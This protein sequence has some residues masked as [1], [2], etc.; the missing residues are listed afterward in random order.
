MRTTQE[1]IMITSDKVLPRN[2]WEWLLLPFIIGIMTLSLIEG[3]SKIMVLY[4]ILL[5]WLFLIYFLYQK[6][7]LQPEVMLFFAWLIWSIIGL[8]TAIDLNLYVQNLK[9]IIQMA[10]LIFTVAGITALNRNLITL[11]FAIALGGAI[12]LLSGYFTGDFQIAS[13]ISSRTR[14][15]GLAENANEFAYLLLFLIFAIFFFWESRSSLGWRVLLL[16]LVTFAV[17]GIIYSGSRKIFLAFLAF[18]SLWFL[19]CQSKK[20]FKNPV[21]TTIILM[22]VSISLFF[23]IDYVMSNTYLGQRLRANN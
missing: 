12:V 4:G 22:I 23:A 18:I 14:A 17:L 8:I 21:P 10:V 1:I 6:L 20:F 7:K 11:M 2:I 19:F 9:T 13:D 15:M 16:T 3:L 5:S